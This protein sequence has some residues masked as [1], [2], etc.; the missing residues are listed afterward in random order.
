MPEYKSIV[1]KCQLGNV[2]LYPTDLVCFVPESASNFF[3][4]GSRDVKK[5]KI[6]IIFAHEVVNERGHSASDIDYRRVLWKL[7][8]CDPLGGSLQ[9]GTVPSQLRW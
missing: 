9:S 5:S 2:T 8:L 7:K 3:Q 6:L 4:G 1:R